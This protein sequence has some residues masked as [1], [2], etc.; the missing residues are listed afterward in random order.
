VIEPCRQTFASEGRAAGVNFE[1]GDSYCLDGQKLVLVDYQGTT[2]AYRTELD[3][4]QRIV[5]EYADPHDPQ[6]SSFTVWRRDG[7]RAIYDQPMRADRVRGTGELPPGLTLQEARV[8]LVYPI[9]KLLDRTGF[10]RLEFKYEERSDSMEPY[11][12]SYRISEISY[13]FSS[14]KPRRWVRFLYEPRPDVITANAYGIMSVMRSRLSAIEAYAPNPNL[15]ELVWR[16][17]L[18]YTISAD[19][20]R[21]LLHTVQLCDQFD[22]AVCSWI[23]SFEWTTAKAAYSDRTVSTGGVEFDKASLSQDGPSWYK[24][25]STDD[26]FLEPTDV[27]LMLF[28][29]DGDGIDEALYRTKRTH[30]TMEQ[31]ADVVANTLNAW[32]EYHPGQISLRRSKDGGPLSG[33]SD[34][35]SL[36]EPGPATQTGPVRWI[37]HLG[38]SRVGDLNGDG[39]PDLLLART[40]FEEMHWTDNGEEVPEEWVGYKNANKWFFGYTNFGGSPLG[41]WEKYYSRRHFN[42]RPGHQVQSV[43]GGFQ[44][45][46]LYTT[47]SAYPR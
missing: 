3:T 40:R 10:N 12:F 36:L 11:G 30:I 34:I 41:P 32:N 19:T 28:D 47:V 25:V 24:Y 6:P 16:Y 18:G 17:Q 7:L 13:S 42:L 20:K 8:A 43:R 21:S 14:N 4:V 45:S 1:R 31:D 33:L 2:E 44:E 5:A 26:N 27:S 15:T 39:L 46:P 37:A 38:K 29:A 22:P 35:T 23:R 9:R